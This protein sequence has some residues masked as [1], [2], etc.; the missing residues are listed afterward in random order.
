MNKRYSGGKYNS[1]IRIGKQIVDFM[2]R[3]LANPI[4][5]IKPVHMKRDEEAI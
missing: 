5:L 4:S 1:Y 2:N 3:Y